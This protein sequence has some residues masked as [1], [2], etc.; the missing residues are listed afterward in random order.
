[1]LRLL[2]LKLGTLPVGIQNQVESLGLPQLEELAM[3]LLE[4]QEVADLGAWLQKF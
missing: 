4:F 3:A 1:M 2:T